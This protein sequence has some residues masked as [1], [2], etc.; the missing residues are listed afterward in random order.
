[1]SNRSMFDTPALP[2]LSTIL[3]ELQEGTLLVP[4]FQ[5][6]FL[7]RDE[8][9]LTLMDSIYRSL[10]IGTLMV[11]RMKR[12]K[13]RVNK[14]LGVRARLGP[15]ALGRPSEESPFRT[16][17]IDGLQRVSTLYAALTAA[18]ADAAGEEPRQLI[19][20]PIYF[21]LD[22][23]P[24]DR[25]EN[26]FKLLHRG[27]ELPLTWMPM[28]IVFDDAR[29]FA[30]KDRLIRADLARLTREIEQVISRFKDYIVP[31][32]P[33]ATD[34]LDIVTET[35]A[36]VN[37]QGTPMG[38]V[39]MTRALTYSKSFD[40]NEHLE[41]TR[42]GLADRGWGSL[43]RQ[44]L[45]NILKAVWDIPVYKAKPEQ[46][47]KKLEEQSGALSSLSG[48]LRDA[49]DL[50]EQIDIFGQSSLPYL[51]QLAGL[52]RAAQRHGRAALLAAAPRL[53]RWLFQT[54]Y[55]EHFS[56]MTYA[57]LADAFDHVES[58]VTDDTVDPMPV[59]VQTEVRALGR[60][61]GGAV[62]STLFTL[63]MAR[64]GDRIGDETVLLR[65]FG[66]HGT[67]NKLLPAESAESTGNFV[68][69]G[70]D[71]LAQLRQ[72]LR[73]PNEVDANDPLCRKHFFP[74]DALAALYTHDVHEFIVRRQRALECVERNFVQQLGLSWRDD[75]PD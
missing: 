56:G 6:D 73:E 49:F 19:N 46:V 45:L 13:D 7:W 70:D 25:D 36:R 30:L 34:E 62:R 64:E 65:E 71:E 10:P 61:R 38:E 59:G 20:W 15:A 72:M 23:Q 37:H 11:W 17:L 3:E 24:D 51:Y 4:E 33:L 69:A 47:R 26:R 9:R 60:F 8:Q 32:V 14:E 63:S 74:V 21:D 27:R 68:I 54:A 42:A 55:A 66:R 75:G 44:Q 43:R 5:R 22:P 2:R 1:M 31:V 40:I 29:I 35:F 67:L 28:S 57:Q 41:Q 52:V 12:S 50:L 48:W 16:Y 53:R 18:S 39:D 58:L